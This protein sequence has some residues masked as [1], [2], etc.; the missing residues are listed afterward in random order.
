MS[1]EQTKKCPKCKEDVLKGA[2]RCKHCQADI[3]SWYKRH[4]NWTAIIA[5]FFIAPIV[6]G[7]TNLDPEPT[8]PVDPAQIEAKA[9]QEKEYDDKITA[10]VCA[11]NQVESMLKS[12]STADFPFDNGRIGYED[13]LFMIANYVDSQNG[14]GAMVRTNYVCKVTV[15]NAENFECSTECV[16]EQ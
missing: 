5:L 4:P 14:F 10:T 1:N 13:G 15:K 8:E 6:N 2:E 3:R 9:Q 16:F 11:Q 7:L 12:P